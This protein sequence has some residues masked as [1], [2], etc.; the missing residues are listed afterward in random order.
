MGGKSAESSQRMTINKKMTLGQKR[1][2]NVKYLHSRGKGKILGTGIFKST[3]EQ[4]RLKENQ[5]PPK[6][7]RGDLPVETRRL[8]KK[9]DRW[10]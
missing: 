7:S 1:G 10:E 4:K 6:R 5:T 3:R 8:S 2:K 9:G